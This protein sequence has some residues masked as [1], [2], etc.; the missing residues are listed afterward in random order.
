MTKILKKVQLSTEQ[1]TPKSADPTKGTQINPFTQ[2]EM[3]ALQEEGTWNGGYVE[4]MGLVP[5][6]A[7]YDSFSSNY[8][9]YPLQDGFLA[10]L[11]NDTFYFFGND[12]S[13]LI[14]PGVWFDYGPI[15]DMTGNYGDLEIIHNF[16]ELMDF[17]GYY[18]T[19]EY[20]DENGYIIPNHQSTYGEWVDQIYHE[21][22]NCSNFEQLFPD[23]CHR[24]GLGYA[25]RN[26]RYDAIIRP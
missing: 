14:L 26:K 12:D 21:L 16:A 13:Y 22:D 18:M 6:M 11:A 7:M 15:D 19:T 2:E 1:S 3:T 17:Y 5:M 25:E 23:V 20:T 8:P 10:K 24:L 4:G 9:T